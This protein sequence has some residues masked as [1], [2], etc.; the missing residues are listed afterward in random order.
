VVFLIAKSKGAYKFSDCHGLPFS[1]LYLKV[2]L[3]GNK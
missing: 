1:K 3:L 2:P